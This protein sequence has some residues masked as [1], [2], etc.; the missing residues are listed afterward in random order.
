MTSQGPE[1][2]GTIH[3]SMTS[4]VRRGTPRTDHQTI[5]GLN[6]DEQPFTLTFTP[7]GNVE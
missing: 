5:I 4:G 1:K 2:K 3:P 7:M 6:R